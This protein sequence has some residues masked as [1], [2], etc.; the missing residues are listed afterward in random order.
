MK[1]VKQWKYFFIAMVSVGL[2]NALGDTLI[3]QWNMSG[4]PVTKTV[5]SIMADTG[6]PSGGFVSGSRTVLEYDAGD[7]VYGKPRTGAT[8]FPEQS[9]DGGGASGLAGDV[10]LLNKGALAQSSYIAEV[11]RSVTTAF[12]IKFDF[13]PYDPAAWA[14]AT[15]GTALLSGGLNR[16]EIRLNT[17]ASGTTGAGNVTLYCYK[18]TGGAVSVATLNTVDLYGWNH[19]EFWLQNG[20][21]NVKLNNDATVSAPLGAAFATV[22]P[23]QYDGLT[24]AARFD[25]AGR[26]AR[27]YIDNI[28]LY[29]MLDG[30]GSWGYLPTDFNEDCVVDLADLKTFVAQWLA[31]TDPQGE[32]CIDVLAQ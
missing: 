2:S 13:K 6:Y 17:I 25:G 11:F 18:A 1:N 24:I 9:P 7:I 26:W 27:A 29:T 5:N 20:V 8:A 21:M 19:V 10:S 4:T 31:C 14:N 3:G 23:T 12:K 32:D 30:C 16:F 15:T 22:L 28:E